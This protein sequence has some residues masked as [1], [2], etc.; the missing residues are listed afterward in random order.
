M[1]SR[2]RGNDSLFQQLLKHLQRGFDTRK[3]HVR[4]ANV[5]EAKFFRNDRN[6]LS[7]TRRTNENKAYGLCGGPS[8]RPSNTGDGN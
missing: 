3:P 2:S 8:A 6:G 4:A 1:D 5:S 7:C